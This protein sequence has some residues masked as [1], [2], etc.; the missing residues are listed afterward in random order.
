MVVVLAGVLLWAGSH[1]G[2]ALVVG[3]D[4]DRPGAILMLAS[5]E[6]E[7]LPV[8]A[9]LA[10]RYPSAM[11]LL[12]RPVRPSPQNCHLCSE[13]V[14]WLGELGIPRSRTV[15]LSPPAA[16]TWEEA[17][18]A[19]QYA[20]EHGIRA[21]LVVTS[22]YHTRRALGT[23]RKVFGG[24]ATDVGVHPAL[25]TSPARPGRWWMDPYDRAYVRYEWAAVAWYLV[26]HG[27]DPRL[28]D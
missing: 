23:F 4:I 16:N 27:V 3:R 8:T 1:A 24:S 11:V 19:R 2:A 28:P 26:R 14:A 17:L 6:W 18:A 5:H 25:E 10:D 15:V 22:P 20:R 12:T 21:L 7:R 9:R 13:R